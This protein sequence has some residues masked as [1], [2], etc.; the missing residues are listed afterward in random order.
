MK[1]G[2]K[3]FLAERRTRIDKFFLLD[4]TKNIKNKI[5]K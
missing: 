4:E 1:K 3:K 2:L 5:Q